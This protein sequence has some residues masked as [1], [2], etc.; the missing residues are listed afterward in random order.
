MDLMR[1]IINSPLVR[2]KSQL[3]EAAP[4]SAYDSV[5]STM[6]VVTEDRRYFGVALEK[7]VERD[8]MDIPVLVL[9]ACDYISRRG[10]YYT[11]K[12]RP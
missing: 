2:R 10:Q 6:P 8:Q 11:C 12:Y 9:K 3:V 4:T 5:D 1:K 7:I